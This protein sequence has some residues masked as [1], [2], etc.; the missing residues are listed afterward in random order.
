MKRQPSEQRI[1]VTGDAYL[2]RDRLWIALRILVGLVFISSAVLKGIAIQSFT[3]VAR[4]FLY[5]VGLDF[6]R[7]GI[8]AVSVCIGEVMIGALALWPNAYNRIHWIYPVVMVFFTYLT[9][10]NLIVPYGQIESCGCFGEVIHLNPKETFV[11]NVLLLG[12]VTALSMHQ[13]IASDSK[14]TNASKSQ[15]T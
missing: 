8:V 6:M 11:K 9:Y 10:I 12:I 2:N 5:L 13:S 4:D 15:Q 7:P 1:S 3:L 14:T